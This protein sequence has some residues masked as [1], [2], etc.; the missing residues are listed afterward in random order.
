LRALE[1]NPEQSL[2]KDGV[3][4]KSRIQSQPTAKFKAFVGTTQRDNKIRRHRVTMAFSNQNPE[5]QNPSLSF[6]EIGQNTE[7]MSENARAVNDERHIPE[8]K[9]QAWISWFF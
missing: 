4:A 3:T 8:L 6:G 9:I 7:P 2:Q 1:Q 5:V